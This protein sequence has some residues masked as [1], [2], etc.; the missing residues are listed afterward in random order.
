MKCAILINV[1]LTYLLTSTKYPSCS[2]I[3]R[4]LISDT[5]DYRVFTYLPYVLSQTLQI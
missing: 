5:I 3:S 1:L 2:F 4:R